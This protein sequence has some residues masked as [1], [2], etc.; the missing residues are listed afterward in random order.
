MKTP[1]KIL[2]AIA[3]SSSLLMS[4]PAHAG[5]PVIDET[6]YTTS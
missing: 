5:I 6:I 4:I 3:L 2:T 1:K